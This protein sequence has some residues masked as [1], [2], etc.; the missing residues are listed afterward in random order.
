MKKAPTK[1]DALQTSE[2]KD[3]PTGRGLARIW[4]ILVICA[5]ASIIHSDSINAGF[6]WDDHKLIVQNAR[7]PSLAGL[8]S[9]W[10]SD[11][12]KTGMKSRGSEYYR[13]LTTSTFLANYLIH[14][15]APRGYHATNLLLY[16]AVCVV[17]WLVFIRLI[18]SEKIGLIAALAFTA[19]P[20]H[21][22]NV[23]WISGRTDL[24][25][26]LFMFASLLIY[27]RADEAGSR[28][29]LAVSVALFALS[30]FGK[31][32]SITLV[33]IVALH[34]ALE[35][36]ICKKAVMT[37]V[38]Y[39]AVGAVFG[40]IHFAVAPK[41]LEENIYLGA[42]D[43]ALNLV[44]NYGLCVLHS[45][46][47]GGSELIITATREM[48][49]KHFPAPSGIAII[50]YAI[51]TAALIALAA[52]FRKDKAVLFAIAAGLI[53]FAPA[54]GVVPIGVVFANRFLLIPSFFFILA[55]GLMLRKIMA[56]GGRE[57]GITVF[58][59]AVIA[60]YS[61]V[62]FV[63]TGAWH[64]DQKLMRMVLEKEPEAAMA[65]F[66][67]GSS[68]A[69]EGKVD[70]AAR[71]LELAVKFR[72][73]YPEAIYNLGVMEEKR[74][75]PGEAERLYR[76]ALELNPDFHMARSALANLLARTGR[77]DEA[78]RLMR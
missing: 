48:A 17:A 76:R 52:F 8:V 38:P 50:A 11:Y 1:K 34:Q 55:I 32:M 56:P 57:Q 25:S 46:I 61:V 18:G 19:L 30:L 4:P 15:D 22:E 5:L 31:E 27:L 24:V 75:R 42:A 3:S 2:G 44:R 20:A 13:P 73:D 74:G 7:D 77:E 67:L 45:V 64:S 6:V 68:L 28:R 72:P 21:V 70:E 69:S 40:A 71:H 58:M 12:W 26:A 78:R 29:M 65:H 33:A 54:S 43:Y 41:V 66:L 60:F 37:A 39:A 51:P 10:A 23:A 53:A 49:P 59:A 36:G 63:Q 62:A 47:P 35:R 16:M 9:L 14:R